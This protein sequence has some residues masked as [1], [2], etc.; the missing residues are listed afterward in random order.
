MSLTEQVTKAQIKNILAALK[1]GKRIS[2][3]EQALIA[4]FESKTL[5]DLTLEVVAAHFKVSRPGALRWKR[6]MAK[7]GLPWTSIE[8]IERWRDSKEEEAT[9]GDI[10]SVKKQ[11]LEREVK[12]LD[13]RIA[14]DEGRLIPVEQVINETVKVV[15]AWCA[16]LDA[17]VNDLPGQLA[18]LSEADILV[19]LKSRIELLKLNAR[20]SFEHYSA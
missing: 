18:G 6:A 4:T 20:D 3:A 10:N 13:I 17:L 14:E 16:E 11:K 1:A 12:R 8:E 7:Q 2:K 5:P 15:S 9:T 19:R